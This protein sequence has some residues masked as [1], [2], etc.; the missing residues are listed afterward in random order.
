MDVQN[1][2]EILGI[3]RNATQLAI[4]NA[5]EDF[6]ALNAAGQ[7]TASEW[8][9]I[10]EAYQ[11]LSDP[12]HRMLY[13][14]V[15][16][17]DE[18]QPAKPAPPQKPSLDDNYRRNQQEDPTA[19]PAWL[20]EYRNK[21]N[22]AS[23]I[24]DTK[25]SGRKTPSPQRITVTRQRTSQPKKPPLEAPSARYQPPPPR[26]TRSQKRPYGI[27]SGAG[28]AIALILLVIRIALRA[29][30]NSD[31]NQRNFIFPT[32]SFATADYSAFSDYSTRSSYGATWT[33]IARDG[34]SFFA[35]PGPSS[36]FVY[37]TLTPTR[38][39]IDPSNTPPPR[40][41]RSSTLER[42]Q[43]TNNSSESVTVYREMSLDSTPIGEFEAG[44]VLFAYRDQTQPDWLKIAE[45][46]GVDIHLEVD[47]ESVS[48]IDTYIYTD[49]VK[50][51]FCINSN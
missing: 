12:E 8:A 29:D 17:Q 26:P 31:D 42:C 30:V 39:R 23:D 25:K 36:A 49:D 50:I 46:Q 4:E 44:K 9:L 27:R 11:I 32:Y 28:L 45:E 15:L 10:R 20:V 47:T 18:I 33:A 6:K 34:N 40:I 35:G 48:I 13:D 21:Q 16:K 3:G 1:Y 38:V 41:T 19:T 24:K 14:E 43:I 2:Y 5:Y 51:D 7:S 22:A 37:S